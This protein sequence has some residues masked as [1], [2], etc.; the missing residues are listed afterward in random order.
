MLLIKMMMIVK[1]VQNV[2]TVIILLKILKVVVFKC[3][4]LANLQIVLV[5]RYLYR[6]HQ[7]LYVAKQLIPVKIIIIIAN[8]LT[9]NNKIVKI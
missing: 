5:K 6:I 9:I 7:L 3:Q 4:V 1:N 2:N 8:A